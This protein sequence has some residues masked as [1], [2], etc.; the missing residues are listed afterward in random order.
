MCSYLAGVIKTG[1]ATLQPDQ[2]ADFSYKFVVKY[3]YGYSPG[4]ILAN[5]NQE[6]SK[7]IWVSVRI[8]F[9]FLIWSIPNKIGVFSDGC[10]KWVPGMWFE[11]QVGDRN[12]CWLT[13]LSNCITYFAFVI[14]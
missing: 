8:A 14:F 13:V 3:D 5:R 2:K 6:K 10:W 12:K 4:D 7:F 1:C 11:S 9:F